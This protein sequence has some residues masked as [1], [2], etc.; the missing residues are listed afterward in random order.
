MVLQPAQMIISDAIES[1]GIAIDHR[2]IA[3]LSPLLMLQIRIGRVR[4][5][6]LANRKDQAQR[7]GQEG[8]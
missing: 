1:I 8:E 3:F 7:C 2:A 4:F 6:V 5:P